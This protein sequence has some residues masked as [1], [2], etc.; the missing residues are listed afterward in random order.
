MSK[1]I[2]IK[3]INIGK[4]ILLGSLSH[5]HPTTTDNIDADT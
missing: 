5:A 3:K 2:A 4:L 1:V